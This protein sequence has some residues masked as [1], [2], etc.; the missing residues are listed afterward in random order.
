MVM[1]SGCWCI[2]EDSR[3]ARTMSSRL[4]P[5]KRRGLITHNAIVLHRVSDWAL[6]NKYI[7]LEAANCVNQKVRLRRVN[8]K[9]R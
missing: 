3:E 8:R 9:K 6:P 2:D 7:S 4:S 1:D 5:R